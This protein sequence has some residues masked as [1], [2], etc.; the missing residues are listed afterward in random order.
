MSLEQRLDSPQ[1]RK[2]PRAGRPFAFLSPAFSTV[3]SLL[4]CCGCASPR[5]RVR[6]GGP[7]AAPG[8]VTVKRVVAGSSV[9]GRPIE[10]HVLGEGGPT[11]LVLASIHGNESAGTPLVN[12]LRDYLVAHPESL[13]GGRVVLM[14]AANPDGL[15]HGQ[16]HNVHGVD[17]NRNFP[18]TNFQSGKRFGPEALSEPESVALH[19]VLAEYKP[20][21]VVS[22][23][24]P[25]NYGSAC[26]DYDGPA[27][28]L[29]RAMA[30][31][32]DLP[33]KRL[34]SRHGS[35]GSYVGLMLGIPIITVELP[36]EASEW[37]ADRLWRSYGEMLLVAVR[38]RATAAA[39]SVEDKLE[40]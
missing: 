37:P 2:T 26:I 11:T 32:C 27:W 1:A 9:E 33:V 7:D 20:S 22:L 35:L 34:G 30:A 24:Q 4:L 18:A 28:G 19:R 25:L 38:F 10:C 8:A 14:P 16:R 12:R 13:A 39:D 21:R 15:A 40:P 3:L 5:D 31:T 36:R 23:H 29:A 17:L 6:A